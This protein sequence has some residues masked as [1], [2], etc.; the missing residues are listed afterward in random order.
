MIPRHPMPHDDNIQCLKIPVFPQRK[1]NS[2]YSCLFI[3]G[4]SFSCFSFTLLRS[5]SKP[6]RILSSTITIPIIKPITNSIK[7][8]LVGFFH[9]E[10]DRALLLH[11]GSFDDLQHPQRAEHLADQYPLF[12][13]R[14]QTQPAYRQ[15]Y[16]TR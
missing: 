9:Q 1:D 13:S 10:C 12:P 2:K 14:E 3:T 5:Y 11:Q 6:S 15:P 16:C 7:V 4:D 8:S